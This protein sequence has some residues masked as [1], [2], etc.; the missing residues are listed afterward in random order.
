MIEPIVGLAEST[1]SDG[2]ELVVMVALVDAESPERLGDRTAVGRRRLIL[3]EVERTEDNVPAIPY[4]RGL[5]ACP[6]EV[7]GF[8]VG[9]RV[10]QRVGYREQRQLLTKRHDVRGPVAAAR[11][12][13]TW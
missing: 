1:E 11:F 4:L 5:R 9:D 7:L 2:I 3:G 8:E 12:C 13:K 6:A 10:G